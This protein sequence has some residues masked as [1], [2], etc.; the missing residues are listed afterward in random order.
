MTVHPQISQILQIDARL[1]IWLRSG[2]QLLLLSKRG[3]VLLA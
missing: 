1:F 2:L 3:R